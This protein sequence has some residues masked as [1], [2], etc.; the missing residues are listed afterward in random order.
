MSA[1]GHRVGLS[2]SHARGAVDGGR[3]ARADEHAA[4]CLDVLVREVLRV[5]D[6]GDDALGHSPD[7]TLL[8]ISEADAR[9][10]GREPSDGLAIGPAWVH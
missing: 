8:D 10:I 1:T 6:A 9:G 3:R 5:G 7:S 2:L 4:K